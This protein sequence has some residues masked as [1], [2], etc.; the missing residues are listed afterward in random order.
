MIALD[1]K[2]LV[3]RIALM[4]AWVIL[5]G[6][7]IAVT[8]TS[9]ERRLLSDAADSAVSVVELRMAR[10][11]LAFAPKATVRFIVWRSDGTVKPSEVR[12]ML[13]A[14]ASGKK[15]ED[16][17]RDPTRRKLSEGGAKVLRPLP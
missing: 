4:T 12:Q 9:A 7:Y 17:V 10:A 13:A 8:P 1:L 6:W 11:A 2:H 3:I 14:I 5:S 16:A 15:L